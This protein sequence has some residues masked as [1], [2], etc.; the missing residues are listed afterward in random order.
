MAENTYSLRWNDYVD[1][2]STGLMELL[3]NHVMC[4]VTFSVDG[5][6]VRAH[7][8]ILSAVSPYFRSVFAESPKTDHSI[9]KFFL[10]KKKKHFFK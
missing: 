2:L 4:D 5:F 7:R 9:S 6:T 1:V 3:R 8:I 10:L